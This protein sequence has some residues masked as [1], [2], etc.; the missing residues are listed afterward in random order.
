MADTDAIHYTSADGTMKVEDANTLSFDFYDGLYSYNLNENV[1]WVA[2][3]V[4]AEGTHYTEIQ[5]KTLTE[6]ADSLLGDSDVSEDE[7]AIL[8]SMKDLNDAIIAL[9][10]ENA[11]LGHTYAPGTANTSTL[12]TQNTGYKFGTSIKMK[13]IEP[14]GVRV[15]VLVRD[16]AAA[17][18]ADYA[19]ADDYGLIFFHDKTG[20]Y[21]GAMTAAQMNAETDAKVYSKLGGN[22]VINANGITAVYDRD[23]FTY[24]LD[25]ELYCLPYIVIDGQYYYPANATCWN[26]LGEMTEFAAD[27]NLAAEERAV[28]NTMLAMYNNVAKSSN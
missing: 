12:G 9:R 23:I 7:K 4:T 17:A 22:A 21:G 14:W 6:V 25:S 24:A 2:Y 11:S 5:T 15:R 26:L 19:N 8:S 28:F 1:Y 20:K 16:V 10:G 13:L 18:Y 3:F 27:T